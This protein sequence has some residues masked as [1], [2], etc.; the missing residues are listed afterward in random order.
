MPELTGKLSCMKILIAGNPTYGLAQALSEKFQATFLSRSHGDCDLSLTSGQK[1]FA[2][3]SLQYDVVISVS[4]LDDFN[5]TMLIQ[6]IVKSWTEKDKD[7][8]II[9]LGSSADTP[10]KGTSWIYPVEKKALRA[11]CRQISQI[12]SGENNT[13]FKMTYLSPGNLHTP[14]QD[15]KM[16]DTPKIQCDYMAD[17]IEWLLAQPKH[18]NI[19]EL[20]LD[21]IPNIGK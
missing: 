16:P 2:E 20:C 6:N 1:F 9:A 10:V 19:N 14:G 12:V 15:R 7:G 21:R 18:I 13:K 4:S 3:H 17:V 8:Y 11:Y 5:Q